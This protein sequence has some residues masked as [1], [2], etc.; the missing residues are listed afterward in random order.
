MDKDSKPYRVFRLM[1]DNDPFS[2]HLGIELKSIE[3]GSCVLQLNVSNLMLNG[4]SIAHGGISYS[5]CDSALAFA[6]NSH[7]TQCVSIETSISHVRP[8]PQNGIMMATARE[9]HRGKTTGIYEVTVTNEK[10][11]TVALFKG[12]VFNTGKSWFPENLENT[13]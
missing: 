8:V 13:K 9:L 2:K 12:T 3:K 5:L 11:K 7:G 4:F 6:A 10:N 1:Y